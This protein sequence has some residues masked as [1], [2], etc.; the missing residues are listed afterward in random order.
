MFH[1]FKSMDRQLNVNKN[2]FTF[3]DLIFFECGQNYFY[4]YVRSNLRQQFLIELRFAKT[5]DQD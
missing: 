5:E 3:I 2:K 1:E 4:S